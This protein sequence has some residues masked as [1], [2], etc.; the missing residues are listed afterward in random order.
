MPAALRGTKTVRIESSGRYSNPCSPEPLEEEGLSLETA[1]SEMHE[2]AS[3]NPMITPTPA[4]FL[5]TETDLETESGSSAKRQLV[6][7]AEVQ[8]WEGGT[9]SLKSGSEPDASVLSFSEVGEALA[10]ELD[11][12]DVDP[13][14]LD[15]ADDDLVGGGELAVNYCTKESA[16]REQLSRTVVAKGETETAAEESVERSEGVDAVKREGA[17]VKGTA[18]PEWVQEAEADEKQAEARDDAAFKGAFT[19]SSNAPFNQSPISSSAASAPTSG[20]PNKPGRSVAKTMGAS[21]TSSQAR[22][23]PRPDNGLKGDP[24]GS[25][26]KVSTGYGSAGD[27]SITSPGE[28]NKSRSAI[29]SPIRSKVVLSRKVSFKVDGNSLLKSV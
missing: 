19:R 13:I 25:P 14:A 12:G 16:Q 15:G 23:K 1:L 21:I 7:S 26:T 8:T 6:F 5:V 2:C 4:K 27:G 24:A 22:K 28:A 29:K 9:A 11:L 10:E 20:N 17:S 18:L 3:P